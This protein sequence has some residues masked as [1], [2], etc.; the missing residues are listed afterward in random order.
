HQQVHQCPTS[1]ITSSAT[2]TAGPTRSTAYSRS[3]FR[4]TRRRSPR[5]VWPPPSSACPGT[6]RGSNTRTRKGTGIPRRPPAAIVRTPTSKTRIDRRATPLFLSNSAVNARALAYFFSPR[7]V[8]RDERV[9]AL[10][11]GPLHSCRLWQIDHGLLD[12]HAIGLRR[13]Q[14]Q[15]CRTDVT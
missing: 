8:R 2:T 13:A 12:S 5:P 1:H 4:P 6:R 9:M 15:K 14:R 3:R 7:S 10:V 11:R